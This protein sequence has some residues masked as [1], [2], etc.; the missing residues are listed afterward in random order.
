MKMLHSIVLALLFLQLNAHAQWVQKHS[1]TLV[2]MSDAVSDQ[3]FWCGRWDAT[4]GTFTTTDGGQTWTNSTFVDP[5]GASVYCIDALNADTAYVAT[6]EIFKTTNRGTTWVK[7]ITNYS[8][9]FVNCVHFFDANNGVATGD[10]NGGY[11]E[12]YTTTN[13]GDNWVRVPSSNIPE[14][15]P[16]EV[17]TVSYFAVY[18]NTFWFTTDRAT[19]RRIIRSTDRGYTWTLLTSF[20]NISGGIPGIAFRDSLNGIYLQA[21]TYVLRT[22]DGGLTWSPSYLIRLEGDAG[23]PSFV[24]GTASTYVVTITELIGIEYQYISLV[25][26]DDGLTWDRMDSWQSSTLAVPSSQKWTSPNS[27][28]LCLPEKGIYKWPGYSGKHIW[29][30]PSVINFGSQD[31]GEFGTPSGISV[32]N[33]G[34][35]PTTINSLTLSSTNFSWLSIPLTPI[36]LQPWSA[37]DLNIEFTPHNR[38]LNNDS[39]VILSDA[40]NLSVKLSGK[41]LQFSPPLPNYIYATSDSLFTLTLSNP[42]AAPVGGFEGVKIEGLTIRPTDSVLIG[43][44]TNTQYSRLYRIDPVLGECML[45]SYIYVG[46]IRAIAYS[47]GGTLFAGAKNG[48]LYKISTGGAATLIGTAAGKDYTALSFNPQNGKLYA[49]VAT[50]TPKDGIYT[51]DTLTGAATILGQTGDGKSTLS[52]AFNSDGTLYGLKGGGIAFNQLISISTVNGSGTV[53]GNLGKRTLQAIIMS[54]IVTGIEENNGSAELTSYELFQNYPNPFNPNTTIGYTLKENIQTKLTLLNVLGEEVAVL[55]NEEQDKGYHKVEL[56]ASKFSSGVYFY[57]MQTG[58]STGSGQVF[59][60]TK[61][62]ILLK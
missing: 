51:V 12:I 15:L 6:S 28:W 53:I 45:L 31:V 25:S 41:A 22:S 56:N 7:Q 42:T 3:I 26:V 52:I 43:I 48:N 10:P 14:P 30:A 62:M 35:S 8:T 61:K 27:G 21:A 38:G 37:V 18:N 55:V 59:I 9:G 11:F 44:S 20:Q 23:M 47:P 46:N 19:E 5:K 34:T 50:S 1:G 32:G 40:A 58:P 4:T 57:R 2:N 49:S 13:G 17:G 24:Q 33:Y 54:K 39:L 16:N 60:D 36:V 29:K